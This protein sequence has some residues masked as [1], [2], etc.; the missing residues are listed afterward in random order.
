MSCDAFWLLKLVVAVADTIQMPTLQVHVWARNTSVGVGQCAAETMGIGHNAGGLT[1]QR[2]DNI[3]RARMWEIPQSISII[4]KQGTSPKRW[5]LLI[6]RCISRISDLASKWPLSKW[7]MVDK[8]NL[9]AQKVKEALDELMEVGLRERKNWL[10]NTST[11]K[12]KHVHGVW[13]IIAMMLPLICLIM[14]RYR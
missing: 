10:E 12:R 8:T 7:Y 5:D 4:N 11:E 1:A 9:D 2:I 3:V 6:N 13:Y 14:C